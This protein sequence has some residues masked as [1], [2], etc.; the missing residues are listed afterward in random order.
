MK[1]KEIVRH[2]IGQLGFERRTIINIY[3]FA[4]FAGLVNLTLPLGIQA[5]IGFISSG[6]ITTSWYIMIAIVILGILFTGITQMMQMS[7]IESI[8]QSVFVR[9]AFQFASIIP[10]VKLEKLNENYA[11]EL[12]NRFFDTLTIQKGLPK[13]LTDFSTSILQIVFGLILLSFYHPFFVLFSIVVLMVVVGIILFT[14]PRGLETSLKESKYKYQVAHWLQEIARSMNTFKL[15]GS[16]SLPNNKTDDLTYNYIETRKKHF[17][18]LLFQYANIITF[19]ILIISGLLILGSFLVIQREIN[20]GQFIASE[21]IIILVVNSVE[22]IILNL[23]NVYDVLT[24]NEKIKQVLEIDQESQFGESFSNH[25]TNPGEGL[26]VKIKDLSFQFPNSRKPLLNNINLEIQKN[27]VICLNGA[28]GSGKSLFIQL[29]GGL[30]TS[31]DGNINFNEI[32]IRDLNINSLRSHIGDSLSQE[33]IFEGT[34]LENIS[35]GRPDITFADVQWA[36]KNVGLEEFIQAQ[37]NGYNTLLVPGG[38]QLS[39]SIILKIII[40]RSVA[41]RPKLLILEDSFLNLDS[42][43]RINL[44]QFLTNRNNGWTLISVTRD[45][46]FASKADRTLILEDGNLTFNGD[47]NTL[48]TT[49]YVNQYFTVYDS[50]K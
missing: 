27:E 3:L 21:I 4:A 32:P 45:L 33:D 1:Y 44:I 16:C 43:D 39:R 9:S 29:L 18:I 28:S 7:L 48:L 13:L 38:K 17:R 19:K 14:G 41:E 23:E 25:I 30:Y 22:K 10:R 24:A 15:A 26:S 42:E 31:F 8:Q 12:V 20:L 6:V 49:N 11:P 40:A 2:F 35:M 50:S 34:L 37:P 46:Y 5:I 36:C 47:F